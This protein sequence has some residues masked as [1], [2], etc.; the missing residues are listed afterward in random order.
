MKKLLFIIPV[1]LITACSAQLDNAQDNVPLDLKSVEEYK[2]Q[3]SSGNTVPLNQRKE[4]STSV[5]H[6][7]NSSDIK[8]KSVYQRAHTPII[9]SPSIGYGYYR[10]FNRW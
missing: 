3:V 8:P 10:G 2:A 9:I 7:L 6:P 4:V 5:E 1:L